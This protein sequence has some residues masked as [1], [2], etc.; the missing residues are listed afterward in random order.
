MYFLLI[1]MGVESSDESE[2]EPLAFNPAAPKTPVSAKPPSKGS[3]V[4]PISKGAQVKTTSKPPVKSMEVKPPSK[5]SDAQPVDKTAGAKPP[6]KSTEVKVT[7][8]STEAKPPSKSTEV[9]PLSKSAETK[10]TSKPTESQSASKAADLSP[11]KPIEA[12]SANKTVDSAS[13]SKTTE[14]KSPPKP[15]EFK[16]PSKAT[17]APFANREPFPQSYDVPIEVRRF[18]CEYYFA[19]PTLNST[20][21]LDVTGIR[22]DPTHP[23]KIPWETIPDTLFRFGT[24]IEGLPREFVLGNKDPD[25]VVAQ[26]WDPSSFFTKHPLSAMALVQ[27]FRD[28]NV[29]FLRRPSGEY[30]HLSHYPSHTLQV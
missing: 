12:Q 20:C 3:E 19:I 11:N 25:Q 6:S 17:I 10:S 23:G 14:V 9:K 16:S 13:S 1:M 29:K 22:E 15:A 27:D 2:D 18:F 24:Y 4:K 30:L 8:K 26:K 21:S 5:S 7:N 28:G